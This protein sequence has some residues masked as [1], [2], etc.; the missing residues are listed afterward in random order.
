MVEHDEELCPHALCR[1]SHLWGNNSQAVTWSMCDYRWSCKWYRSRISHFS[2][3]QNIC[4]PA[5][6]DGFPIL[7]L[8]RK[9]LYILVT[10]PYQLLKKKK[11][12]HS[13]SKHLFIPPSST[14]SCSGCVMH[15]TLLSNQSHY[16]Y[17]L[18][19]ATG[20][21]QGLWHTITGP[22]LTLLR[23]PAVAP[24]HGDPVV[25]VL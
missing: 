22:S 14:G 20:L 17:S 21:V 1:C 19:W 5:S 3:P 16:K 7:F 18:Q 13:Q 4:L 23:Y 6:W 8:S 2:S 11:K 12:K 24:N 15:Y 25:I 9:C 10:I